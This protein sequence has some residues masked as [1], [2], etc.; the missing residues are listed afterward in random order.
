[1]IARPAP[2]DFAPYY[3]AYVDALTDNDLLAHLR[4]QPGEWDAMLARADAHHRYAP[5]KWTV[6][7]VAQHVADTERVFA[8]RA[9]RWARG[10][11]TE[12]PGF[13]Q[14][15]WVPHDPGQSLPALSAE[16][17]AVRNATLALVRSL[18]DEALDRSGIAS[19][20][21]MTVRAAIWI[22]AGHAEHHAR[23]L[24]ERYLTETA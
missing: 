22:V 13:D 9:L 4:R 16:L 8:Y 23:I 11:E 17:A 18:S 15:A 3:H 12:L 24:R 21:R 7:E 19:G 1:M 20:R 6:R 5:G 2:D 10:D 14:D